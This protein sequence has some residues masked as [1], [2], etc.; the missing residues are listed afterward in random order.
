MARWLQEI[1]WKGRARWIC[2]RKQKVQDGKRETGG[3]ASTSESGH[4]VEAAISGVCLRCL[5]ALHTPPKD[6]EL[7]CQLATCYLKLQGVISA[8][9]TA[10]GTIAL[11]EPVPAC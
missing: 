10:G 1:M 8:P 2:P 4:A 7:H 5:F 3:R 11:V 9:D 6:S